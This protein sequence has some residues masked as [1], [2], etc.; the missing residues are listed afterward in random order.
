VAFPD[1]KIEGTYE[2]LEKVAEGETRAIYRVRHRVLGEVRALQVIRFHGV[3]SVAADRFLGEAHGVL[4]LR[5]PNLATPHDVSIDDA[6]Y[7]YIVMELVEGVTLREAL[8]TYGPPPIALTLEI[9]LQSLRAIGYLHTLGIVHRDLSPENLTL[10]RDADGRPLVKLTDLGIAKA[11]EEEAERETGRFLGRVR[12]ASPEQL[13][14]SAVDPRADLY[15]FAVVLYE[16]LTG[17]LPIDGGS[18]E[19]LIAGHLSRRPLDFAETD[20]HGRI[21]ADLREIVLRALAKDPADRFASAEDLAAEL[22]KVQA[23]YPLHPPSTLDAANVTI[24]DVPIH[25]TIEIEESGIAYDDCYR[26]VTLEAVQRRLDEQAEVRLVAERRRLLDERLREVLNPASHGD[27]API[28]DLARRGNSF[29]LEIGHPKGDERMD[30][31]ESDDAE[32]VVWYGTNRRPRD[33]HDVARGFANERSLTVS[34]GTCRVYVPQA[35]KIGSIGSPWWKRLLT[36]TDDRLR[37]VEQRASEAMAFWSELSE[38]L[39]AIPIDERDAVVFVHGYNVSFEEAAL[40]AAQIGFDLS[41]R[42]AMAF[43]SWPSQGALDGYSADEAT[44]EASERMI[45][46]FIADVAARSG[47]R[48]VHVIAHSMGNRAVLRAVNRIAAEVPQRAG[49]RFGQFILAAADVDADTF[50]QNCPAYARVAQRATLYV[51]AKDLAIEASRWLHQFPRAGLMPPVF[52]APG[53]DTISVTNVDLS[54]LGHGYVAAAR[55]VLH[56]IHELIHHGA[57]PDQ[58]FGLREA[59]SETGDSYWLVGG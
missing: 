5:H 53:I 27:P 34:Y 45:T 44:I 55:D 16:L 57:P 59:R 18:P 12:Y 23:S 4:R 3:P 6:G 29:H 13:R 58:R 37:L 28:P 36:W 1:E 11:L 25:K 43:F 8:E 40:R 49:V 14:D 10:R 47:A 46:D 22:A 35:H 17:R 48:A 54:L 33:P 24:D 19:E 52:V 32:Y 56:D 51:S 2:I 50:R 39:A 38:H 7:A 21:P 31:G 41:V 15:S 30:R 26:S 20:L 9:A 42:G